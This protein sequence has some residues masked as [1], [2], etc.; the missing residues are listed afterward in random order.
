VIS[1]EYGPVP[2]TQPL[3]GIAMSIDIDYDQQIV[4]AANYPTLALQY[5]DQTRNRIVADW[6][7][8]GV[9]VYAESHWQCQLVDRPK[10]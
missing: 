7:R 3:P 10:F 8:S 6:P 1:T 9:W 4:N 2:Q 5:Q